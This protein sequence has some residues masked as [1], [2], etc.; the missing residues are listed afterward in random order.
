M[1]GINAFLR[2]GQDEGVSLQ[3]SREQLLALMRER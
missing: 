2:Q 1:D 3:A